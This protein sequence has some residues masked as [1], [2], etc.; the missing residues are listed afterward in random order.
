MCGGGGGGGG[1]GEGGGEEEVWMRI[2]YYHS[3]GT[4]PF[5]VHNDQQWFHLR[6]RNQTGLTNLSYAS[7]RRETISPYPLPSAKSMLVAAHLVPGGG[8]GSW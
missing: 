3:H 5:L 2:S 4:E 6:I 1:G 7:R 8:W